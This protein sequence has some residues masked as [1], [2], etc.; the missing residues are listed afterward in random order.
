MQILLIRNLL[1]NLLYYLVPQ[2]VQNYV[3]QKKKQLSET[4]SNVSNRLKFLVTQI[5]VFWI[6]FIV[7]FIAY[8]CAYSYLIPNVH[9]IARISFLKTDTKY[10]ARIFNPNAEF[11]ICKENGAHDSKLARREEDMSNSICI[12]PLQKNNIDVFFERENYKITLKFII[13]RI[14]TN[15]HIGTFP[16]TAEFINTENDSLYANAMGII[17]QEETRYS[18]KSLM[19]MVSLGLGLSDKEALVDVILSDNFANQLFDVNVINIEVP[20]TKLIF[21]YALI[22]ME[23][24]LTSYR[25][26]MYYWF[27]TIALSSLF[28]MTIALFIG[29]NTINFICHTVV[30]TARRMMNFIRRLKI[31]LD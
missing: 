3:S 30:D 13:P 14:E 24:K 12:N 23:A 28:W 29:Y 7:A 18:I 11:P 8:Y 9:Q 15:M 26:L 2:F 19:S 4:N 17:H 21:K 31:K 6:C 22:E 16:I 20:M 5:M 1:R 27:W 25:Y 10:I